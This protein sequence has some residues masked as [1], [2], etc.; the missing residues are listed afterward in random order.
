M[1]TNSSEKSWYFTF[2]LL[3]SAGFQ[4]VATIYIYLMLGSYLNQKLH[5]NFLHIFLGF[6]GLGQGF[7]FFSKMTRSLK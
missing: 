4:L 7:F 6:I 2:A 5:W 3:G 1:K